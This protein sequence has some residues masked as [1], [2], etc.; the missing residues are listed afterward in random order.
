MA[1]G[2]N[3]SRADFRGLTAFCDRY[4]PGFAGKVLGA[5]AN[6]IDRI[7]ALVGSS[8][9]AEY[10]AFMECMGATR[11][12]SL[13]RFLQHVSFGMSAVEEYYRDPPLPVPR[14]AIYLWTYEYDSPTLIF[15]PKSARTD[16]TR[17]LVQ[18]GWPIDPVTEEFTDGEPD[19]AVLS[20]GLLPFLYNEAFNAIRVPSLRFGVALEETVTVAKPDPSYSATRRS[21]FAALMHRLGFEALPFAE[22]NRLRFDRADAAAG[23]ASASHAFDTVFVGADDERECGRLCEILIDNLGLRKR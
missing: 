7:E 15:L 21:E 20:N 5:S 11:A 22:R 9:P 19:V 1:R 16:G 12:G 13:G 10:R 14:D 3:Q 23:M 4:A 17:P 18:L 8:L 6:E 2:D